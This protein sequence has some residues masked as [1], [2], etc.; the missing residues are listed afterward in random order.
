MSQVSLMESKLLQIIP[1][2]Y[3]MEPE[4]AGDQE[5]VM[6][7]ST[8]CSVCFAYARPS[9]LY[10]VLDLFLYLCVG[11]AKLH[12]GATPPSVMVLFIFHLTL[13][14]F[15]FWHRLMCIYD[16]NLGQQVTPK[17]PIKNKIWQKLGFCPD[18]G[19]GGPDR[20]KFSSKFTKIRSYVDKF[21][22]ILR[23]NLINFGT[24]L[25]KKLKGGGLQ[26]HL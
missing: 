9:S 12:C 14:F 18:K 21:L 23:F 5:E 8:F 16:I 24:K 25:G 19:G 22:Y 6:Q 20:L 10:C 13:F 26:S 15:C 17:K 2:K 7:Q 4:P 1:N 11:S 3:C